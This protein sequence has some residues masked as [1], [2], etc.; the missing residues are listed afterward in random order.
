[1]KRDLRAEIRLNDYLEEVVAEAPP[2]TDE[3]R[4]Q[5]TELLERRDG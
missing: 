1:V 4:T 3:Q 5:L 2:V